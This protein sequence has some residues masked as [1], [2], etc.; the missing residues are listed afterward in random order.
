[1]RCV[2]WQRRS[3]RR[4]TIQ[5]ACAQTP[6]GY[7]IGKPLYCR[8]FDRAGQSKPI[9]KGRE[10]R[11]CCSASPRRPCAV[12]LMSLMAVVVSPATTRALHATRTGTAQTTPR[13]MRFTRAC[14]QGRAVCGSAVSRATRFAQTHSIDDLPASQLIPRP[15]DGRRKKRRSLAA[16]PMRVTGG[17]E[18]AGLRLT[19]FTSNC[20]GVPAALPSTVTSAV[21]LPAG[22][23]LLLANS[24]LV[25]PTSV[26]LSVALWSPATWP[27]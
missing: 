26:A 23:G 14:R 1:M 9:R 17:R 2:E 8:V 22:H 13:A 7:R 12:L 25:V 27:S 16:A 19:Y 5:W 11:S 6:S 24:M 21:Y 3:G 15:S 4:T 20:C 10:R 18:F